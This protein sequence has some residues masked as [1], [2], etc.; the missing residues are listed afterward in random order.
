MKKVSLTSL[1]ARMRKLSSKKLRPYRMNWVSI[2]GHSET[3]C[4]P[5]EGGVAGPWNTKRLLV[6]LSWLTGQLCPEWLPSSMFSRKIGFA[7]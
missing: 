5:Q 2:N 1:K 3:I 7:Q 6:R 4:P